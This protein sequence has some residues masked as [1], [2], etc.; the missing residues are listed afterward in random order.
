VEEAFWFDVRPQG[1][2]K[3]RQ[4]AQADPPRITVGVHLLVPSPPA[5][6]YSVPERA[7]IWE[8]ART[9]A[10]AAFQGYN[11][12]FTFDERTR[13]E[14]EQDPR[15]QRHIYVNNMI[16]PKQG[17]VGA[18]YQRN[19]YSD[20]YIWSLETALKTAEGCWPKDIDGCA[21][22]TE[23]TRLALVTA[24]GRGLGATAA[25]ELGHQALLG[26][27][28]DVTDR[29]DRYDSESAVSHDHFFNPLDWSDQ[30]KAKMK[31]V[32]RRSR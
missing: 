16:G 30:A 22:Q 25:H 14:I 6:E 15:Q 20:V 3:Q 27:T 12:D 26:F 4:S 17:E 11:V 21:Q 8:T 32:L 29:S 1:G 10:Q 9:T 24:L 28:F 2:N 23:T 19:L 7:L 18:T 13:E 31:R 5:Y